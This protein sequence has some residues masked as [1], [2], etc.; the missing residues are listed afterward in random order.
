MPGFQNGCS[1]SPSEPG[2][3]AFT[4]SSNRRLRRHAALPA[5]VARSNRPNCS[6]NQLT[7]QKPRVIWTSVL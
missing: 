1:I 2:G 7:I 5:P 3:T 6:L 4:S